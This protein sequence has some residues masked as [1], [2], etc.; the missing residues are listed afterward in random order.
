MVHNRLDHRRAEA[1]A[2]PSPLA[3]SSVYRIGAPTQRVVTDGDQGTIA[4]A[5]GARHDELL[6]QEVCEA[7][8]LGGGTDAKYC[9]YA[10]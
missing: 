9:R 5:G 2:K 10:G 7:K 8:S 1:F 6:F 4:Q 3:Q